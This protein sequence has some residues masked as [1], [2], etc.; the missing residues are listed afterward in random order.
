[1]SPRKL[2][3]GEIGIWLA[4]LGS[5]NAE[6]DTKL[7]SRE[8]RSRAAAF[9]EGL[10]R[11]RFIR[12]RAFLRRSLAALLDEG[13]EALHFDYG[14]RGKPRLQGQELPGGL[15]FNLSH[16]GNHVLLAAA[17]GL[18]L[19]VDLEHEP[20]GIDPLEL[21]VQG[22]HATEL[23]WLKGQPEADRIPAF[24]RLW[25]LKEALLKSQSL[26]LA[27]GLRAFCVLPDGKGTAT[28]SDERGMTGWRSFVFSP[29]PALHASLAYLHPG[30]REFRIAPMRG[31]DYSYFTEFQRENSD[32]AQI[33]LHL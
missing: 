28:V 1:M 14:L 23:A 33:S 27:S 21:A 9:P 25:T 32:D 29:Q 22:C 6:H 26:E 19:G 8:E 7:L 18:E 11:D 20:Q 4:D 16:S 5:W 13:A 2:E 15:G 10:Y 17:W 3:W 12:S 24:T 30:G 31:L